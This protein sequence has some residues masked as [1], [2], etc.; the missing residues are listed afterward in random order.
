MSRNI[1]E[2]SGTDPVVHV[3]VREK[4]EGVKAWQWTM[5]TVCAVSMRVSPHMSL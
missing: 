1:G 5:Y 2:L 4:D 3:H